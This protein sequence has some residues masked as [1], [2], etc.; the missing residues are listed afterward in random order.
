MS[1]GDPLAPAVKYAIDETV[2]RFQARL[3]GTL[4]A[5][6]EHAL[7]IS[8]QIRELTA[9]VITV[10]ELAMKRVAQAEHQVTVLQTQVAALQGEVRE[11]RNLAYYDEDLNE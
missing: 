6:G 7:A 9:K 11:L 5:D 4:T 2:R 8:E 10:A 1:S 3:G